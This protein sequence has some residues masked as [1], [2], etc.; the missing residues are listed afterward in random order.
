MLLSA[1]GNW[2]T[3]KVTD[4][5]SMFNG[6]TNFN[7]NISNWDMKSVINSNYY[8]NFA[9]GSALTKANAPAKNGTKLPTTLP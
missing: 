8:K 9:I 1:I 2:N 3:S 6:A 4:I 7:Q 5:K